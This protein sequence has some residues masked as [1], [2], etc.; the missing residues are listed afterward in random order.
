MA[1]AYTRV[2]FLLYPLVDRHVTL[3]GLDLNE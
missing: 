3:G 2:R 1:L